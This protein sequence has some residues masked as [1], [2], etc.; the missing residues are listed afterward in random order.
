MSRAQNLL[1]IFGAR[2][3]LENREV[4]LPRMDKAGYDKEMVYK[5]MF[6]YLE[7]WAETGG[8]CDAKEFSAILPN[9]QLQ[10]KGRR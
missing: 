4:K 2:N 10:Q 8:I 3:M 5:N 1:L 7:H 6:K 9:I